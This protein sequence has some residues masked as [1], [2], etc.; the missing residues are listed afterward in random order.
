MPRKADPNL[1][2]VIVNAA[3]RILDKRGIEAVTMRDVAQAAGTTTPTLYERFVDRDA[4]LVAVLD[5]T[6]YEM[7][8]RMEVTRNVQA[9]CEEFLD[10]CVE[11]PNRLDLVHKVWPRT[12]DAD[13]KRPTYDLAVERLIKQHGHTKK[14]A[15]EIAQSIMAV[16]LGSALMMVGAGTKTKFAEDSR[17]RALKS[18]KKLCE[19]I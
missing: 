13:R 17:R 16:L 4:L 2:K 15:E 6:A 3:T 8:A 9:M 7:V 12:V 1:E 11:L 10:Y 18:V 14:N 5:H 19:G